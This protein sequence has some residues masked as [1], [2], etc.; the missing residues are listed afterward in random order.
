[1]NTNINGSVHHNYNLV[2]IIPYVLVLM[3]GI[4]GWNV[5]LVLLTGIVSER[6]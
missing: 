3:G 2:Q 4:I 5:F 1:M 6:L